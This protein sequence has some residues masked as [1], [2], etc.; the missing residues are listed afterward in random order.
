M[1]PS[2]ILVNSKTNGYVP[3]LAARG[4]E[5]PS[6]IHLT[7]SELTER[8]DDLVDRAISEQ[9]VPTLRRIALFNEC[10]VK[11]VYGRVSIAYVDD[12]RHIDAMRWWLNEYKDL[13]VGARLVAKHLNSP[14][15]ELADTACQRAIDRLGV[16]M[17]RPI[18]IQ[19]ST[20]SIFHA[21]VAIRFEF[22]GD[23]LALA[24]QRLKSYVRQLARERFKDTTKASASQ[25]VK[26]RFFLAEAIDSGIKTRLS[27]SPSSTEPQPS[28][29]LVVAP[30]PGKT[31]P[32]DTAVRC[33]VNLEPPLD[34]AP[35]PPAVNDAYS[36]PEGVFEALAKRV[37]LVR[38]RTGAACAPLSM[39]Q[40]GAVCS[41]LSD[42][43][44]D[45]DPLDIAALCV[46]LYDAGLSVRMD[47]FVRTPFDGNAPTSSAPALVTG[48]Q[49]QKTQSPPDQRPS[50]PA[51]IFDENELLT[52][53]ELS[54]RIKYDSRT[55]RDRLKDTVLIKDVH[56]VRPFGGRKILFKWGPI[57][58]DMGLIKA[59][60]GMNGGAVQ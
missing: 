51:P 38:R 53:D 59:A 54:E 37:E 29:Q 5:I 7:E 57:A 18:K 28:S 41:S 4:H 22:S 50:A 58:R 33:E 56:Y 3:S 47:R 48:L 6:D 39:A 15:R 19:R 43:L 9:D 12:A 17:T 36:L 30:A 55:I 44:S 45:G 14:P 27:R 25:E 32:S 35:T 49:S 40:H 60:S 1:T 31:P 42:A 16:R 8:V 2:T 20:V 10:D 34:P 46:I 52:T 11:V 24:A 26:V 13:F 23:S 21:E